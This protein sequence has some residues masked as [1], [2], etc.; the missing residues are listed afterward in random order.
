MHGDNSLRRTLAIYLVTLVGALTGNGR[1]LDLEKM[2]KEGIPAS[3]FISVVYNYA[4]AMLEHGRD[5]Y[6]PQKSGL[7]LS[8]LDRNTLGPLAAPPPAPA[9][10]RW[11]GR[12]GRAGR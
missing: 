10:V 11:G 7:F 8:A 3:P 1:E 6:G 9:G 2:F 12:R 5:S 4:N